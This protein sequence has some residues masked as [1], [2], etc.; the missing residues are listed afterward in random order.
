MA[1]LGF[2]PALVSPGRSAAGSAAGTCSAQPTR[3]RPCAVLLTEALHRPPPSS[4]SLL[5]SATCLYQGLAASL[6][7]GCR[8]HG[9]HQRS[10]HLSPCRRLRRAVLLPL[11]RG[12]LRLHMPRPRRQR[13]HIGESRSSTAAASA[14]SYCSWAACRCLPQSCSS[15]LAASEL[16]ARLCLSACSTASSICSADSGGVCG[17]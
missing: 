1:T 5:Q 16:A 8:S 3:Q 15:R 17:W 13:R 6:Q 10:S 2:R 12:T 14:S 7:C 4:L 9:L 11:G